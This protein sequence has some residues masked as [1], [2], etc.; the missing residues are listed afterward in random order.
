MKGSLHSETI[1]LTIDGQLLVV[2]N[3]V[4]PTYMK[5]DRESVQWL[6]NSLHEDAKASADG[7]LPSTP[8]NAEV[9][10]DV[11]GGSE[12]EDEEARTILDEIAEVKAGK[13]HHMCK[14]IASE[15]FEHTS[16]SQKRCDM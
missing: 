9:C 13:D 2:A 8:V 1:Q 7:L 16:M 10:V 11:D 6:I 12:D 14:H 4:N 3:N 5:A 15:Y